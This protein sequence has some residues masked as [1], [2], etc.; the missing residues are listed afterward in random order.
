MIDSG[1][2]DVLTRA[3][4]E[5]ESLAINVSSQTEQPGLTQ[6]EAAKLRTIAGQLLNAVNGARYLADG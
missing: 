2:R 4:D 1:T 6:K 5:A 3:A